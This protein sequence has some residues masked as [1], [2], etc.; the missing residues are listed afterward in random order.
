MA[1]IIGIDFCICFVELGFLRLLDHKCIYIYT[2][3]EMVQGISENHH[4]LWILKTLFGI[5]STCCGHVSKKRDM[6]WS[7]SVRLKTL[8]NIQTRKSMGGST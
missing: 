5:K 6:L 3:P 4:T 2:S 8:V 1:Y 7:S